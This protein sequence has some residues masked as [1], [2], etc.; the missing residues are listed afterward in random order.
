[1]DNI[2]KTLGNKVKLARKKAGMTQ[3][4]LAKAVKSTLITI[5]RFEMGRHI[6]HEDTLAEISRVLKLDLFGQKPPIQ[7]ITDAQF[8]ALKEALAQK[9][10][11]AGG[12]KPI[13]ENSTDED[14]ERFKLQSRL[15]Q[16]TN[17]MDIKILHH[18]LRFANEFIQSIASQNSVADAPLAKQKS[19]VTSGSA[20]RSASV[21]TRL[22]RVNNT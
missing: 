14:K 10:A 12:I 22:K 13:D 4:D 11:H 7:D 2:K 8:E 20:S 18:V 19:G 16:M 21:S 17:V 5:N 1:M 6:P 9:Q 15:I 3:T